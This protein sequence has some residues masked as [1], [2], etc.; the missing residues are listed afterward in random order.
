[1]Y[2]E[3]V[4]AAVRILTQLGSKAEVVEFV[5]GVLRMAPEAAIME[6]KS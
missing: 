5:N 1:M 4:L 6:W 3:L 2:Y